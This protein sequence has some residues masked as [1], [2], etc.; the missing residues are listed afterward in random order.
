MEVAPL[1]DGHSTA[2]YQGLSAASTTILT[3]LAVS[4]RIS[5]ALTDTTG[6]IVKQQRRAQLVQTEHRDK[7]EEVHPAPPATADANVLLSWAAGLNLG[8]IKSH[9][10]L[11]NEDDEKLLFRVELGFA[12]RNNLVLSRASTMHGCCLILLNN[13]NR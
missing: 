8:W 2:N 6:G 5:E 13:R 10:F 7:M 3:G 12:V 9:L 11:M 4:L 1:A